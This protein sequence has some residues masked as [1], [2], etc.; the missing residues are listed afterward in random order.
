ML[1]N[2]VQITKTKQYLI[3]LKIFASG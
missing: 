3:S 1:E 2:D